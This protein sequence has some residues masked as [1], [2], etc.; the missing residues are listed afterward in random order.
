M[1]FWVEVDYDLWNNVNIVN[2]NNLGGKGFDF[3]NDNFIDIF[4]DEIKFK[5][6]LNGNGDYND[7]VVKEFEIIAVAVYKLKCLKNGFY[8]NNFVIS[9]KWFFILSKNWGYFIDFD[10]FYDDSNNS[11]DIDGGIFKDSI[12]I[13]I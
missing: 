4:F 1:G 5:L 3:D 10:N 2:D 7:I 11:F 12:N 13:K 9:F 8:D 6:D